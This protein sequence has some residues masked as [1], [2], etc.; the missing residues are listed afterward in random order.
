MWSLEDQIGFLCD[1]LFLTPTSNTTLESIHVSISWWRYTCFTVSHY[2]PT[3][4]FP[5]QSQS[6]FKYAIF[7]I[8]QSN[9]P[10][11][12]TIFNRMSVLFYR[13]PDY[14][15]KPVG[16]ITSTECMRYVER[17]KNSER[18]IPKGLSFE[19]VMQ[20]R[21]LPVFLPWLVLFQHC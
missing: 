15:A 20:Q 1:I 12:S 13:R 4:P 19:D 6:P 8:L 21:S 11:T 9:H 18:A 16:P 14:L 5:F 10:G 17:A 2:F 3:L 7:F